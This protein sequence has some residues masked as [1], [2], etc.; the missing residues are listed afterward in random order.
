MYVEYRIL[1]CDYAHWHMQT[2]ETKTEFYS[3]KSEIA[4]ITDEFI[5]DCGL[6][7]LIMLTICK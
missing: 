4:T 3:K 2:N 1:L 7:I 6:L 5:R